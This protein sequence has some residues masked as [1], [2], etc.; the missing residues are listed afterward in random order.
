VCSSLFIES[1]KGR[2]TIRAFNW[3]EDF[4][5]LNIKFLDSSQQ[6]VYLLYSVQQWLTLVLGLIS[7][8]LAVIL[9]TLIVELRDTTNPALGGVALVTMI[10]LSSNLMSV[11]IIWTKLETSIGAVAR[12]KQFA[13]ETPS[14]DFPK[15]FD[16]P[17]RDWPANGEIEFCNISATYKYVCSIELCFFFLSC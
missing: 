6:P 8:A 9:V 3:Q 4:R 12:V 7:A 5:S 13:R 10:S 1:L 15:E 2:A 16:P 17:A 14:E 11:V